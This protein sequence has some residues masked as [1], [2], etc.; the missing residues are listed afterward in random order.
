VHKIA[1]AAAIGPSA[2]L[3]P[4]RLA[5]EIVLEKLVDA[6]MRAAVQY[7][8]AEQRLLILAE[9]S[10][11]RVAAEATIVGD[12]VDVRIWEKPVAKAALAESIVRY[13]VRTRD[14]VI[15]DDALADNPF[16]ADPYILQQHVRSVLCLPLTT[17]D[18]V[19]GVLYLENNP[20]PRVFAPGR[21][22]VLQLLASLARRWRT[23]GLR[24]PDDAG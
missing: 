14:C 18:K 19:A 2:S 3:W 22:A 10:A 4:R 5:G 8:G 7:A 20:A 16:S 21:I 9:G 11:E 6:L 13:V 12:D 23:G 15:L 24:P 1:V 17:R